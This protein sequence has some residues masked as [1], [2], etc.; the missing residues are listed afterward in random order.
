MGFRSSYDIIFI[1]FGYKQ[2]GVRLCDMCDMQI[3]YEILSIAHVRQLTVSF[4][5]LKKISA[6]ILFRL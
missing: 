3:C 4:K 2:C 5:S 1:L 6:W